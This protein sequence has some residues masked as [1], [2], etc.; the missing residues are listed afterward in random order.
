M[1]RSRPR[2][3]LTLVA[4]V[5]A[6]VL[7]VISARPG[8]GPVVTGVQGRLQQLFDSHCDR[9]GGDVA[10]REVDADNAAQLRSEFGNKE[11]GPRFRHAVSDGATNI[12]DITCQVAGGGPT[13]FRFRSG[14][15]MERAA[16]AYTQPLCTLT[17]EM[18]TDDSSHNPTAELVRFC[19]KLNGRVR[20]VD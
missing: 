17:R 15:S 14:G 5:V 4:L 7:F 20:H 1:S 16:H 12:L 2:L 11:G 6:G 13:Y 8:P 9:F 19:D 3:I 18:F 10:A